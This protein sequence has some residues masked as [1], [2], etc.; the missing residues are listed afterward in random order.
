V[1]SFLLAFPPISYMRSFSPRT[2]YMPCP[3]YPPWLDQSNYDHIW[4]SL[5]IM[6][7]LI[8]QVSPTSCHFISLWPK[9]SP[10]HPVLKH[11]QS[12]KHQTFYFDFEC[13]INVISAE[14]SAGNLITCYILVNFSA[15]YTICF[16][17]YSFAL[18]HVESYSCNRPWRP[19]GLWDA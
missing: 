13:K 4:R 14:N 19:I 9:Y 12:I 15:A 1:V 10:Q 2:C 8:M 3:S 17:P 11:P 18:P 6:K 5:L 16:L 7:L